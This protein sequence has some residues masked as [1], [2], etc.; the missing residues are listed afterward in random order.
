[1]FRNQMLSNVHQV[2]LCVKMVLKSIYVFV[3]VLKS[4]YVFIMVLKS[5]SRWRRN[6]LPILQVSPEGLVILK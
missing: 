3:V 6:T 1:M 4:I 2:Y 5:I